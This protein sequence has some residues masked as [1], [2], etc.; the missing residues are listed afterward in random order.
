MRTHGHGQG[1]I[2]LNPMIPE[3]VSGLRYRKGAYDADQ[4]DFSNAGSIDISY[5]NRVGKDTGVAAINEGSFGNFGHR[6]LLFTGSPRLSGGGLV[7]GL[8][9]FHSDGPWDSPDDYGKFNGI[10]RYSRGDEKRGFSLS[11]MAYTGNW[12]STDQVPQRAIDSG[13]IGRFGAIDPSG[14]GK[15]HRY[16]LS[17]QA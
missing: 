8:E 17:A 10:L 16:S 4:G 7:Y 3:L 1:W 2:D 6:R 12:N 9:L 11:G 5:A 15:A 14:G 13:L